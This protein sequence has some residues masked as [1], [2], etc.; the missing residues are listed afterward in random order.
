MMA[1]GSPETNRA[2]SGSLLGVAVGRIEILL[3]R[4]VGEHQ[5][6]IRHV[7]ALR[8]AITEVGPLIAI[9]TLG[10]V[11]AY[12]RSKHLATSFSVVS[13]KFETSTTATA[14]R[15]RISLEGVRDHRRDARPVVP[16]VCDAVYRRALW[17][18]PS[19]L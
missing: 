4:A 11:A 2:G 18:L 5:R 15:T 17:G 7:E 13:W 6:V 12:T 1:A 10:G 19:R 9:R 8:G 3:D 16:H 14:L